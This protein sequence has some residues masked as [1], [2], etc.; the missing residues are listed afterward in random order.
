MSWLSRKAPRTKAKSALAKHARALMRRR[1]VVA[2]GVGPRR[3]GGTWDESEICIQIFVTRKPPPDAIPPRMM[4]PTDVGGVPTDVIASD[5]GGLGSC[6]PQSAPRQVRH[7]PMLGG[8]ALA[9]PQADHFGT[10]AALF[11]DRSSV[12]ALTVEHVVGAAGEMTAQP[13]YSDDIMGK[14]RVSMRSTQANL[15]A[16][17]VVVAESGRHVAPGLHDGPATKL[18]TG[19]ISKLQDDVVFIH[20]ACHGRVRAK[21]RTNPWNGKV[22]YE[23]GKTVHFVAHVLVEPQTPIG[24]G[25]SGAAVLD[26]D[27]TGIVGLIV[28][29]P[30]DGT[31]GVVTPLPFV[32]D[33]AAFRPNGQRLAPI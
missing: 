5:F 28:G 33:R 12:Y 19:D 7:D 2:V 8:I 18:R 24:P 23:D 16:A 29:G 20:G 17:L 15:D 13:F 11:E 25:D 27:E 3:R 32:L 14:V 26:S 6:P 22:T 1:G 4:L 31:F 9:H 21:I 10:L 30:A